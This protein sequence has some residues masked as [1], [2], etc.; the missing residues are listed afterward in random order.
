MREAPREGEQV[1]DR[2][3]GDLGGVGPL[4]VGQDDVALDQLGDLH[5]ALHPGAGLLDPSERLAGPDHSRG[6]E[7]V[8]GGGPAGLLDRL[9]LAPADDQVDLRR[10]GFQVVELGGTHRWDDHLQP[11][12]RAGR[13]GGRRGEGGRGRRG[14]EEVAA[15]HGE[16]PVRVSSCESARRTTSRGWK[17]PPCGFARHRPGYRTG[18][19]VQAVVAPGMLIERAKVSTSERARRSRVKGPGPRDSQSGMGPF[20]QPVPR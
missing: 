19:N 5:Q 10:R 3:V 17:R 6:D 2:L 11:T 7:A 1:A 8:A 15:I 14:G 13:R 18:D 4:H 9:G 12:G 20:R 16:S